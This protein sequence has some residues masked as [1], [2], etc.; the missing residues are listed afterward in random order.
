MVFNLV[1]CKKA[2][3]SVFTVLLRGYQ[4][5]YLGYKEVCLNM[6]IVPYQA[7]KELIKTLFHH[8]Y[9]ISD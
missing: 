5:H 3:F 4:I 7:K 6:S 2:F 9:L 1:K 8:F